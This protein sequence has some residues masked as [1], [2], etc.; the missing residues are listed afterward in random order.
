MRVAETRWSEIQYS[1]LIASV[2]CP[3]M[4]DR[5]ALPSDDVMVTPVPVT[6][7]PREGAVESP[8]NSP[9]TAF[10]PSPLAIDAPRLV[11][12]AAFFILKR[13]R[14][15]TIIKNQGNIINNQ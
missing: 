7:N 6:P 11:R 12:R 4:V 8:A 10:S 3:P 9:P 1:Q 13:K 14:V 5:G 2:F 15:L